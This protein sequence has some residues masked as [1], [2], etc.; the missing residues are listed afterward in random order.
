M[1][2]P[3]HGPHE[4]AE[5]LLLDDDAQLC[6]AIVRAL[7]T[8]SFGTIHTAGCYQEA[9]DLLEQHDPRALLIDIHLG[10]DEPDGI[11]FLSHAR[12]AGFG[13]PAVVLS[14]DATIEQFFRA[15]YVGATDYIVKLGFN[16]ASE[17][18][19][20]FARPETPP[21][22]WRIDALKELS[23]CRAWG[24]T[25]WQL[26]VLCE[27]VV[28]FPTNS[29]I[30]TRLGRSEIWIKQTF[31]EIRKRTDTSSRAELAHLLTVCSMVH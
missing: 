9:I 12:S 3:Q 20:I 28:G 2:P 18:M 8:A 11:A 23:Y 4:N 17:L 30:A 5:V 29:Q 16:P 6:R 13:G 26:A 15:A 10:E 21:L 24:L 14:G 25:D 19:R 22:Q 31:T 1:Q 7:R 27:F